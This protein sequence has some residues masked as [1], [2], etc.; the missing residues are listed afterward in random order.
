MEREYSGEML[1]ALKCVRCSDNS[2]PSPDGSRCLPCQNSTS[3]VHYDCSCP[4]ATHERLEDY[5]FPKN[6]IDIKDSRN[7]YLVQWWN[8]NV[9]SYYL[10]KNLRLTAY[11]CKVSL[12]RKINRFIA[13]GSIFESFLC[14]QD[15]DKVACQ[16]LSNI[17]TMTLQTNHKACSMT[18]LNFIPFYEEDGLPVIN[19]VKLV[20]VKYGLGKDEIV[21]DIRT[22]FFCFF[23]KF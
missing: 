6:K 10:R 13:V 3:K 4:L 20:P 9:D 2:Y 23:F 12:D 11:L 15:G 22:H 17:C 1:T 14:L 18:K 5:C 7:T 8:E 19:N 16:K 21:S